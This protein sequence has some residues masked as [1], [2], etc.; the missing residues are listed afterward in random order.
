MKNNTAL[1]ARLSVVAGSNRFWEV[2]LVDHSH[3]HVLTC[4]LLVITAYIHFYNTHC[5]V[6]SIPKPSSCF[7]ASN[8]RRSF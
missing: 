1:D 6:P 4:L 2:F 5:Y 8:P 7:L 3:L